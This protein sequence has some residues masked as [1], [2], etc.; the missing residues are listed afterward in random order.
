[1]LTSLY[2]VGKI[3]MDFFLGVQ[4]HF[5]ID[6]IKKTLAKQWSQPEYALFAAIRR[7]N[8]QAVQT[9]CEAEPALVNAIAPK[10]P[11]TPPICPRCKSRCPPDGF[12]R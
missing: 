9:M 5:T 4:L 11:W 3:T 2:H 7:G 10:S 1:M 12:G 6:R 8:L